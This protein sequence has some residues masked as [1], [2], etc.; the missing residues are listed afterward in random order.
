MRTPRERGSFSKRLEGGL[1]GPRDPSQC[2]F[3]VDGGAAETNL[4][5][6]FGGRQP[7]LDEFQGSCDLVRVDRLPARALALGARRR[8][9]VLGA[10]GD[11]P[12][13]E[14][15]DRP[16]D[17]EDQFT[18]SRTGVDLLLQADECDAAL[19][20]QVHARQQLGQRAP[21]P[22]EAHHRQRVATAGV[23]EEFGQA[24]PIHALARP[25]VGEHADGPRPLEPQR[26]PRDVL[27]AGLNRLG[28]RDVPRD[29]PMPFK[30]EWRRLVVGADGRIDRKLYESAVFAHLR[31]RWRSGDVWVERS[32]EYRRFDSYLLPAAEAAPIAAGLGLA[33]NAD[34]WLTEKG[35][36]L[37][38]RLRRFAHRLARGQ[39]EGVA[40][41][42]GR[43]SIAP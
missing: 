19:L 7:R 30:K 39:V 38:W 21:E 10:L 13:L 25:H 31:N 15:G 26:L 36:E 27:I 28:K 22:V 4:T 11:Q 20:E 5:P 42:D 34:V 6:R 2:H 14:M 37:D 35:R 8:N 18:S 32:G 9:P 33:A 17:V 41:K 43:L 29:A 12:P 24:G 40:M 1:C 16:K 23:G 3:T